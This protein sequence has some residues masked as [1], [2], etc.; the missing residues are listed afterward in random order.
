M[1]LYLD[2]SVDAI[3]ALLAVL[4]AGGAY[5]PIDPAQTGARLDL[6][7][8]D[9]GVAAVMTRTA[10]AAALPPG[11]APGAGRHPG[12]RG[13]GCQGG[14]GAGERRVHDLYLW[15]D[16][17]SEGCVDRESSL[18]CLSAALVA[19]VYTDSRTARRCG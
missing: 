9:S 8:A 13:G 18:A 10:M 3:V 11:K 14:G 4:E 19:A 5:V 15:I 7:L 12:G 2:R 1:A 17:D 16:G 6:I